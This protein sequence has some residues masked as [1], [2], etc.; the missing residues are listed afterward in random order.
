MY[1]GDI[2]V[3]FGFAANNHYRQKIIIS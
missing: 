1:F 3:T 2:Y